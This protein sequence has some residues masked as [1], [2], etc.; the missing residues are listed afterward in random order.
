MRRRGFLRNSALTGAGLGLPGRLV[1]QNEGRDTATV[2]IF[3]TTDLHGNVL[4]TRNYQGEEDLGGLARCAAQIRAW[5]KESPHSLVVDVG[6]VYQGTPLGWQ[7]RGRLMIDLFNKIGY[8]A[9]VLGNHEFDWGPEVVLDALGRSKMPVL[10]ANMN[11]DGKRAGTWTDIGH[12]Y[13][14]LVPHLVKNLGGFKVGLIGL[15]TPGLPYWLRPELLKGFEVLQP[16]EVL[17]ECVTFLREEAGVDA[18]VACGHMGLQ[19]RDDFANP[20]RALLEGDGGIDVFLGGHTHRNQAASEVDGALYSQADYFGIHCGRVDLVFDRET[21]KLVSKR[22]LTALMD[23]R[24]EADPV[25]LEVSA[26]ARG[27]AD[28]YL[29]TEV[30]ELLGAVSHLSGARGQASPLQHLISSA[31]EMAAEQDNLVPD[32]VFHGTFGS[33]TMQPGA[34]T[35]ADLWEVLPYENKV[36]ALY[37]TREEL[38]AVMNESLRAGGDR[39]LYGFEVDIEHA[40]A[41][42]GRRDGDPFV[43]SLRSIRTPDAKVGHRF[44]ILVN[45]YDTQSGGK[46]L[47]RL[48]ALAD[49]PE[50][51]ATLLTL[52]SR[53]ALINFFTELGTVRASGLRPGKREKPAVRE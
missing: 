14:R 51:K 42:K 17:Q 44:C 4:P 52:S 10:T 28:T 37:L 16:A 19:S 3:H 13:A 7:T 8:D 15:V 6:D 25:V 39:A 46:R 40:E 11:L 48:R 43:R 12:P 50:C 45:S 32:G 21:R 30:G 47:M 29:A 41:G 35:I 5:R 53:E 26:K 27:E 34:K 22:A 2:S 18:V 24:I 38:V 20:T 33:G 1:G 23:S 31:L 36:V 49:S 9:W